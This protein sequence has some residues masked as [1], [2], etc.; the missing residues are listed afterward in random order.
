MGTMTSSTDRT[1]VRV[2]VDRISMLGTTALALGVGMVVASGAHLRH[3]ADLALVGLVIDLAG[4]WYLGRGLMIQPSQSLVRAGAFWGPNPH[5]M[6]GAASDKADAQLG[7]GWLICGFSLQLVSYLLQLGGVGPGGSGGRSLV[8]GLGLALLAGAIVLLLTAALRPRLQF[9][10]LLQVAWVE[11][12]GDARARALRLN[13]FA[14]IIAR[15]ATSDGYEAD[16]VQQFFGHVETTQDLVA[17]VPPAS[18]A[19]E[20]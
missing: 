3:V 7:V 15:G 6:V 13:A 1:L 10:E 11:H 8:A 9:R 20:A 19:G 17:P 4:A 12:P 5:V 16:L 2:E 18:R 14:Q